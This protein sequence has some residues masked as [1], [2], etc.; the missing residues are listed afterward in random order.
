MVI[1]FIQ[2]DLQ[3]FLS[4]K[5][6]LFNHQTPIDMDKDIRSHLQELNFSLFYMSRFCIPF[7]LYNN[8]LTNK[9]HKNYYN[10][11]SNKH[12]YKY[13]DQL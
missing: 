1:W 11:N 12:E 7:Y 13:M 10:L 9:P 6:T 4:N 2:S 3:Y 8:I 5:R